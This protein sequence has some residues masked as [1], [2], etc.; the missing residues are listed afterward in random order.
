L[1]SVG[2]ASAK[3]RKK[4]EKVEG[5]PGEGKKGGRVATQGKGVARELLEKRS[6]EGK[7]KRKIASDQ[8]Q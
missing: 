5:S 8:F 2:G 7:G 6:F 3:T 1:K 4:K